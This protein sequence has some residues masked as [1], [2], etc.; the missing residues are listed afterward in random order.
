[1]GRYRSIV[2][3]EHFEGLRSLAL[4]HREHATS[5]EHMQCACI[6][7]PNRS[8]HRVHR[9]RVHNDSPVQQIIHS[10]PSLPHQSVSPLGRHQFRAPLIWTPSADHD[11]RKTSKGLTTAALDS[12]V[13]IRG[14]RLI[15][16][17]PSEPDCAACR[18]ICCHIL[19]ADV[20]ER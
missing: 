6:S 16:P 14:L 17:R 13:F 18:V 20:L 1:M 19:V 5:C 2:L 12:T 11:S 9:S 8:V 7:G 3:L 10:C 4:C 15:A